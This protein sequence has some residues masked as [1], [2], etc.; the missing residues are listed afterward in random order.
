MGHKRKE[1]EC[2]VIN[3]GKSHV[4]MQYTCAMVNKLC[5]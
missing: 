4:C 2:N 5:F 1:G 3:R